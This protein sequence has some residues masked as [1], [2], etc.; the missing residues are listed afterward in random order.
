VLIGN[1]TLMDDHKISVTINSENLTDTAIYMAIDNK[2]AGVFYVSDTIRPGAK[3]MIDELKK[4]CSK[5]YNAYGRQSANST[6]RV[7]SVRHYLVQS[8]YAAGG[9][10]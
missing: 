4:R 7:K 3:E 6:T 1:K 9:Q 10:N 8:G 5:C 2:A